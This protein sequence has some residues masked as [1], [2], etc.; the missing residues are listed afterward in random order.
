MTLLL[1]ARLR[2][3]T[4]GLPMITTAATNPVDR[5]PADLFT[6]LADLPDIDTVFEQ[7]ALGILACEGVGAFT[8]AGGRLTPDG[9]LTFHA[10]SAEAVE[11]L[12]QIGDEAAAFRFTD[13]VG[14]SW[15]LSLTDEG[16][17]G[18]CGL[19]VGFGGDV[20]LLDRR[21]RR[22]VIQRL[23]QQLAAR[24]CPGRKL[25]EQEVLCRRR[26]TRQHRV[27]A[28]LEQGLTMLP[29]VLA[30]MTSADP[31][32]EISADVL[33][34]AV[35][36]SDPFGRPSDWEEELLNSLA[37]VGKIDCIEL[38]LRCTG[39]RPRIIAR[40]PALTRVGRRDTARIQIQVGERFL[41]FW[42]TQ[43]CQTGAA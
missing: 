15:A 19:G 14:D 38:L 23:D 30:A 10:P 31:M 6:G 20:R 12:K 26:L 28:L 8:L 39:W 29:R 42:Q 22:N 18:W 17:D 41:D 3:A 24:R 35:W 32:V 4:I 21:F 36:G 11:V 43:P 1:E 16:P 13:D 5:G 40:E 7:R 34:D 33:A 25:T 9:R 2:T 27:A 37:M